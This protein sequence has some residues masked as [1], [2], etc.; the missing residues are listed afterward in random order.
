MEGNR[1]SAI[2][3]IAAVAVL[4]GG[5][6]AAPVAGSSGATP[7]ARAE[8]DSLEL[9][10]LRRGTPN[11]A[12]L[13]TYQAPSAPPTLIRSATILTAAGE[14]LAN[15]DLLMRAGKIE[16]IGRN[17]EAPAGATLIDGTGRYVTPGLI[18]T[19]SH[20]G[21]SATPEVG[22]HYDNNETGTT[23]PEVWIQ[24]SIWPQGPGF[25][26]A[27]AGGVTTAHLLPG[28]GDL[29]EGRSVTV[30]FVPAR[31]AQEMIFP[32]A[33]HGLKMACGENPKR[34]AGFPDTRMGNVAGSREA[35]IRAQE[36]RR[37]WDAWLDE[38][39]GT[40]PARD[41]GMET[42]AEA[43]RGNILL[44]V[45]CYRADDMA[46]ILDMAE[47]FGLDVRSF[48]HAVE[49]YKIRDYLAEQNVAASVWA[50]WW[51]FKMEAL[52]GIPQNA[53]LVSEAGAR[54]IIHSDDDMGIQ[55]LNQ[56]AAK[57]MYA[58]RRAGVE[59]SRD[60]ALRWI[61][62]NAAW[63]LG[64]QNRVGTL[65]VGKNADVVLWSG[66]PFDIYAHADRVWIDGAPVYDRS[67]PRLQPM[68]DFELGILPTGG[69]R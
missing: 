21:V 65:E 30:K 40:P 8:Y 49:A 53:A 23:T 31:T 9:A 20:L 6:A 56:E 46:N 59:I 42:L 38:P 47:E 12:W 64:I 2:A 48:H 17:L 60:E 66:D 43:L 68:S 14:A 28:S 52:D 3:L 35:W 67:D 16:A 4:L 10:N 15:A 54:A 61:T 24:H 55:R 26:H 22:A 34:G 1:R 41:L 39:E 69:E 63:A 36:Y 32:D 25:S 19:H 7:S 33:P 44:Q 13:S 18:D 57:A 11:G 37:T 51:G 50:D 58:G 62:A 27:L 29:I 5:C 45:H